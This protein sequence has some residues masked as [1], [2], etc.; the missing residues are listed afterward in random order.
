MGEAKMNPLYP[1]KKEKE[2]VARI[3]LGDKIGAKTIL[4]KLVGEILFKNS[5]NR[6]V[7]KARILELIVVISRAAVEAGA[8]MEKLLGLNYTYLGDLSE[9]N[10]DEALYKWMI[11]VFTSFMDE[12]SRSSNKKNMAIVERAMKCMRTNY[13]KSLTLSKIA[14][15][16]YVNA[17]YLSHL[18]KKELGMTVVDYLTKVRIEEAKRLLQNDKMSIIEIALEVGYEDQSYFSKVFKRNEHTTPMVYRKRNLT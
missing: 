3:K 12:V 8:N 14:K 4:N 11:K 10:E 9:I 15:A 6:D 1:M 2:L 16:A 17:Y 18:F 13:N 7:R 5:G